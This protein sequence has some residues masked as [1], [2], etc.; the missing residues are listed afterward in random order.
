[1]TSILGMAKHDGRAEALLIAEY[2]R[3]AFIGTVAA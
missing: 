2:G 3:R 1:M